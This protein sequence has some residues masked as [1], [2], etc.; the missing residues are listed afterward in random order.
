[1]MKKNE[2]ILICVS[3]LLCQIVNAQNISFTKNEI[4]KDERLTN[5]RM[6]TRKIDYDDDGDQDIVVLNT[7]N[8]RQIQVFVN[9]GNQFDSAVVLLDGFTTSLE[10]IT[11]ADVDHDGLED[12]VFT[13]SITVYTLLN[14]GNG[15]FSSANTA[16]SLRNIN[17]S[18][19]EVII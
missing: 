2:L 13:S 5:S 9:N 16:G 11:V 18:S 14:L 3:L 8:F 7:G 17:I 19:I 1:M 10:N 6:Q 15:N 12:I 4:L